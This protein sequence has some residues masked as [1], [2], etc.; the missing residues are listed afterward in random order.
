MKALA[1]A[2]GIAVV[3]VLLVSLAFAALPEVGGGSGWSWA[4]ALPLMVMTI[5]ATLAFLYLAF[6]SLSLILNL[7]RMNEGQ[8][9]TI[10]EFSALAQ[11]H[12][13][14]SSRYQGPFLHGDPE[15]EPFAVPQDG[16]EERMRT[17]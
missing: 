8:Q 10:V 1:V 14:P 7:L 12:R 5:F 15:E 16:A 13:A 4:L 6:L 9:R 2:G 3:V 17:S 11:A